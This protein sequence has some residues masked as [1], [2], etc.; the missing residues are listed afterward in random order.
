VAFALIAYTGNIYQ[1]LWYPIGVALMSLV[2]G[3]LFLHET[4]GAAES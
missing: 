1:G 2:I 4:R 3:G